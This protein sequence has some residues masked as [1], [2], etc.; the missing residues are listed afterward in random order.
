MGT[1]TGVVLT[2]FKIKHT[3][4]SSTVLNKPSSFEEQNYQQKF[5]LGHCGLNWI[6]PLF[7]IFFKKEL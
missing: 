7:S 1:H 5:M 4:N 3:I 2:Q 6:K